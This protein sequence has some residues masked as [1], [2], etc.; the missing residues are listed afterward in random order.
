MITNICFWRFDFLHQALRPQ[1]HSSLQKMLD[2][3]EIHFLWYSLYIKGIFIWK[4]PVSISAE[5][6][7]SSNFFL[8]N[9]TRI[10]RLF[11]HSFFPPSPFRIEVIYEEGLTQAGLFLSIVNS[12]FTSV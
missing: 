7:A 3:R 1:K 12:Q 9:P 6:R 4:Y 8:Q 10:P 2:S 11:S 5:K